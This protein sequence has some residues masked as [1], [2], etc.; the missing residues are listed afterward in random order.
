MAIKAATLTPPWEAGDVDYSG[1]DPIPAVPEGYTRYITNA[2][3]GSTADPTSIFYNLTLEPEQ[4]VDLPNYVLAVTDSGYATGHVLVTSPS[5]F[6]FYIY[7]PTSQVYE[8]REVTLTYTLPPSNSTYAT[9][10]VGIN[11]GIGL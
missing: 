9:S 8:S 6:T 2:V 5:I 7:F 11:I 1:V 10:R 3:Y 4:P